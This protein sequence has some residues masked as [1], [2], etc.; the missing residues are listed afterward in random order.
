MDDPELQQFREFK[1]IASIH[2][3]V[4]RGDRPLI[5]S[6]RCPPSQGLAAGLMLSISVFDL[7]QESAEAVGT[8]WAN[9][10]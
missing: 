9:V 8:G 5:E 6:S 1:F 2:R 7:F 10:W 4:P 3:V